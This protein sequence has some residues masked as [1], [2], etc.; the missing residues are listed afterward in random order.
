MLPRIS[1]VSAG[2]DY[3]SF[4]TGNVAQIPLLETRANKLMLQEAQADCLPSSFQLHGYTG[5]RCG[6]VQVARSVD[7]LWVT[8]IGEIAD[9][10]WR[11]FQVAGI[12]PTRIDF[13]IT[14]TMESAY[15]QYAAHQYKKL[16][17][18]GGNHAKRKITF[19]QSAGSGATLYLGSRKSERFGRLYD[20]GIKAKSAGAGQVWR[21]EVE[22]KKGAAQTALECLE[23]LSDCGTM[24]W[25]AVEAW[26]SERGVSVPPAP[27]T[28]VMPPTASKREG[29]AEDKLQWLSSQVAPSVKKLCDAGKRTDV[30]KALNLT[31]GE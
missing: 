4:T 24:V 27:H 11:A 3:F 17:E 30:L 29:T 12:T 15:P 18:D 25:M 26:F 1:S 20:R 19:I 22:F 2:V 28:F 16:L 6:N 9:R 8:L 13:Q 31:E 5:V 23:K 10:H 21:W 7:R 14:A